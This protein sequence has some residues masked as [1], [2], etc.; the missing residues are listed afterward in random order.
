MLGEGTSLDGPV[1]IFSIHANPIR[2]IDGLGPRDFMLWLRQFGGKRFVVDQGPRPFPASGMI[3]CD[4]GGDGAELSRRL[5]T[6]VA[7]EGGRDSFVALPGDLSILPTRN[8]LIVPAVSH[9]CEWTTESD[10]GF[11][12]CPPWDYV[13]TITDTITGDVYHADNDG[14]FP[15]VRA[16]IYEFGRM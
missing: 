14:R 5:T 8:L 7:H 2:A 13:R 16:G 1:N 15:A 12:L 3:T 9:S 10:A 11:R 6:L 4:S